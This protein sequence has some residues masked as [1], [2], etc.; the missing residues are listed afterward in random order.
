M[1]S[2][3]G[4][5]SGTLIGCDA[6]HG[7]PGLAHGTS[8]K[9]VLSGQGKGTFFD[10]IREARAA[11]VIPNGWTLGCD[12]VHGSHIT[13][14]RE[15]VSEQSAPVG[16]RYDDVLRAAEYPSTDAL[17]TTFPGLILAIRTADCLPLFLV[18]PIHKIIGLAHCGWRGLKENLAAETAG[19][20]AGFGISVAMMEAWMGPC[21]Q[22]DMYEVGHELVEKFERLYPGAGISP[23][24]RNLDLRTITR[25][26]L[27]NAGMQSEKIH[28]CEDCTYHDDNR[29]CSYR[30]D[31]N[32]AGR[33]LSFMGFISGSAPE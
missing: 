11:G 24:G 16:F 6:W 4:T 10:Q 26:Q 3:S 13:V 15:P 7:F 1:N 33:M 25:H 31:G 21:I 28:I 29:F 30:R 20:M 12:Q 14:V 19:R 8:L 5:D 9:G 2:E 18:D 32:N 27:L 22:H 17:I 23:N